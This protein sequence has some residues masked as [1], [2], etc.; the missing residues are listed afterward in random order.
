M[1]KIS[2]DYPN[3]LIIN[4]LVHNQ[5]QSVWKHD[6]KKYH[7]VPIVMLDFSGSVTGRFA[8]DEKNGMETV[9]ERLVC[10]LKDIAIQ[11]SFKFA[12]V[13]MWASTAKHIGRVK[14]A[15]MQG[16]QLLKSK[17]IDNGSTNLFQ[18]FTQISNEWY[19]D[20]PDIENETVPIYIFTDGEITDGQQ[21]LS[22]K[23]RDM[24]MDVEANIKYDIRMVVLE[25]N[26]KDYLIDNCTS[27]NVLVKIVRE[28]NLNNF[29]KYIM[30]FNRRYDVL[31]KRFINL[32]NA[33]LPE[34]YVQY[35]DKCFHIKNYAL[36]LA[37]ITNEIAL[38][39]NKLTQQAIDRFGVDE[40]DKIPME[41][42][43][44][45][46]DEIPHAK[47]D[48]V[49]GRLEKIGYNLIRTINDLERIATKNK[50]KNFNKR[51]MIDFFCNLIG[52]D[53]ITDFLKRELVY[54]VDN[55]TFQEYKEKRGKL[56]NTTQ[57][58]MYSN[59]KKA[60]VDGTPSLY[61][62]FIETDEDGA[63]VYEIDATDIDNAINIGIR[64]YKHAGVYDVKKKRLVPILPT[65]DNLTHQNKQA[66]RQW[67]RAIYSKRYGI[68]A[69]SDLIHYTFLID[70]MYIQC[71]DLPKA[72]KKAYDNLTFVMMDR[73]RYG[74]AI[75]EY[76]YLMN[77]EPKPVGSN[78]N[79]GEFLMKCPNYPVFKKT[80]TNDDMIFNDPGYVW[81]M[82]LETMHHNRLRGLD[83][84]QKPF[85]KNFRDVPGLKI[86]EMKQ[87]DKKV[88]KHHHDDDE[89]EDEDDVGYQGAINNYN[90]KQHELA[91]IICRNEW[92]K[93]PAL[94]KLKF[95]SANIKPN[96][97]CFV[98]LC[99][100]DDTGGYMFY[101]HS[102]QGNPNNICRPNYVISQDAYEFHKQGTAVLRCPYCAEQMDMDR[103][104]EMEPKAEYD[105]REDVVKQNKELKRIYRNVEVYDE[106]S[107]K[108]IKMNDIDF[109]N[110]YRHRVHF[111]EHVV[112]GS[113]MDSYGVIKF[114][115]SD[116][117]SEFNQKIPKFLFNIDFTNIVV[118]G[119]M[120]RSILLGQ[121]IQDI[122]IFFIGLEK[123]DIKMRLLILI[124][125]IV[126]TLQAEDPNYR[127]IMMYKPLNNVVEILCT[128]S[129]FDEDAVDENNDD[130]E[131]SEKFLFIQNEVVHKVQIILRVHQDIQ[132]IFD[133]FDMYGSCVAFDGKNTY[134]NEASYVAFKYMVN[135]V[136][137]IK[138]RHS[139]YNHRI[140]KY[141]K[142]GFAIGLDKKM[143][144]RS[145]IDQLSNSPR[146]IKISGCVF[147][148]IGMDLIGD[149]E[150]LKD[151]RYVPI[152]TFKLEHKKL[153]DKDPDNESDDTDVT[154]G[155]RTN[156][157]HQDNS[158]DQSKG[159]AEPM[160]ESYDAVDMN[161]IGLYNY[162][163]ENGIKFCY[164]MGEVDEQ[165]IDDVLDIQNLEF[166]GTKR[167]ATFNWYANDQIQ[168]MN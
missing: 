35:D 148:A 44:D 48:P 58:N 154:V 139:S 49:I 167:D 93:V 102:D 109:A 21:E 138:S 118:A 160:Y 20:A 28:N 45:E 110:N 79:F 29:I 152:E 69:S 33:Q 87:Q 101:R 98:T 80:D 13:I 144:D 66:I 153:A 19:D 134:F 31:E 63:E 54:G 4:H 147:E 143:L 126:T 83:V 27:G 18:A 17:P 25:N 22:A 90:K 97:Y 107:N 168:I 9:F 124:N 11:D 47:T 94:R 146:I 96:Y 95:D 10:L 88:V 37:D 145:I 82:I 84:H 70:N 156:Q 77:N 161:M 71:S 130:L 74:Q 2:N 115:T 15:N 140:M 132:D 91:T 36:F 62:S 41:D 136:D 142:Y 57:M 78:D 165:E 127:F 162:M 100:T 149:R 34:D 75:K 89:I 55:K 16:K 61:T 112:L 92:E 60:I 3:H 131:I 68:P 51:H 151:V 23:I 141:Y 76:V 159:M 99:D 43:I 155:Q 7:Q 1:P 122:D 133:N 157:M 121:K 73:V 65:T 135:M 166:L 38:L 12:D 119:G 111:K 137:P 5:M 125:D 42:I 108:L 50:T 158:V 64:E 8:D 113:T 129:T 52:V 53:K 105:K 30:F 67:I 72:I 56:F 123:D 103:M 117:Q 86:P 39:R 14:V 120:I 128:K 85:T 26:D 59:L 24:N 106:F 116:K 40:V 46:D 6:T 32:Y 104:I 164:L 150:A 114:N 163:T 81:G